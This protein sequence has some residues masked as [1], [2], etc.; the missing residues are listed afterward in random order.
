MA[1]T[2]SDPA[3]TKGSPK[4]LVSFLGTTEPAEFDLTIPESDMTPQNF[5]SIAA[6]DMLVAALRR[7]K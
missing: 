6:I 5:R 7:T 2:Q 3:L 4:P 1:L